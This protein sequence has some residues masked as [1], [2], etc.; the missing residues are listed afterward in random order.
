MS[1][2]TKRAL[3]ESLKRQLERR[4]LDKITV[5]ELTDEC[6]LN[7]QTFYY[8]FQDI[9][10]LL[11]F[12]F[13]EEAER[14]LG[15]NRTYESWQEGFLN[16]LCYVKNHRRMVENAYHSIGREHLEGY[17]YSVV[18][19]LLMGVLGEQAQGLQVSEEN[20]RFIVDFYMF[21]FVGVVLEWI[22]TG[23]KEEPRA[24]TSRLAR[25][26]EGDFRRALQK[27]RA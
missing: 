20:M 17:L 5:K 10:D 24:L 26:V 7:R 12:A 13:R 1:Q 22:R 11:G 9:Y 21:G 25:L 3:A 4:P 27:F 2:I 19:D 8:H 16:A 18:S 6:G 14:T 15:E 23:Q